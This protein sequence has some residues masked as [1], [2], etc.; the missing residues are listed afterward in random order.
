MPPL[1]ANVLLAESDANS[2]PPV[3]SAE[4]TAVD[5]AEP[6]AS[7][8]SVAA[9]LPAD[10]IV[11]VLTFCGFC[12]SGAAARCSRG[13]NAG[14]R[15]MHTVDLSA[16][17]ASLRD[18]DFGVRAVARFPYVLFFTCLSIGVRGGGSV[19]SA[20]VAAPQQRMSRLEPRHA[21]M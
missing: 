21:L 20:H 12:A 9:S 18:D 6:T 8:D 17:A 2:T 11:L 10:L 4:T 7:G 15:D 19:T 13:W 14:S 16:V 3:L 5:S 1:A